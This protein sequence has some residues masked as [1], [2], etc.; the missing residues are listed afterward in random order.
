M[1]SF[2]GGVIGRA[3]MNTYT[4]A[5]L[6]DLFYDEA[7]ALAEDSGPDKGDGCAFMK[8]LVAKLPPV[9][10][11][12]GQGRLQALV[13]EHG[14]VKTHLYLQWVDGRYIP[15]LR[16]FCSVD[17]LFRPSSWTGKQKSTGK[18]DT[19]NVQRKSSR[20]TRSHPIRVEDEMEVAGVLEKDWQ[21]EEQSYYLVE[22]VPVDLPDD[23]LLDE[24]RESSDFMVEGTESVKVVLCAR[25][26]SVSSD[27]PLFLD[28]T[29]KLKRSQ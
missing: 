1:F 29:T 11:A 8:W 20:L 4:E 28:G 26:E 18:K 19:E 16:S 25:Q 5:Y 22:D 9:R 15:W 2:D 14:T 23:E 24:A 21:E 7:V 6:F 12:P 27:L 13:G 3:V 10:D 17:G